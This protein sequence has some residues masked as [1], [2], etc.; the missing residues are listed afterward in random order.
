VTIL[1][2]NARRDGSRRR[3]ERFMDMD[4]MDGLSPNTKK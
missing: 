4:D 1:A 3:I 2:E